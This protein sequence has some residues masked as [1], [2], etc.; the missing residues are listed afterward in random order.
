MAATA[1]RSRNTN[2]YVWPVSMTRTF[3]DKV[4]VT[5][6]VTEKS[7]RGGVGWASPA[8]TVDDIG[9]GGSSS[10]SLTRVVGDARHRDPGGA[11]RGCGDGAKTTAGYQKLEYNVERL[12]SVTERL[13]LYASVY[14]QVA[15]QNWTARRRWIWAVRTEC[16]PI[17]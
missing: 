9:G 17:R 11:G 1:D 4:D 16:G 7:D 8:T 12:Q 10:Y 15:A 5:S 14:G 6:T 13:S 3:E 2:L